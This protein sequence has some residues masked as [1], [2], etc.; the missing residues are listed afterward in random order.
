M[1]KFI[2][3]LPKRFAICELRTA[4][5]NTGPI[6][7]NF[8]VIYVCGLHSK[9]KVFFAIVAEIVRIEQDALKALASEMLM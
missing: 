1:Q 6:F 8:A 5:S 2:R 4:N 7:W 3:K 9:P